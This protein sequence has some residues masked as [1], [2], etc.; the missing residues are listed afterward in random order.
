M[1]TDSIKTKAP[2]VFTQFE[3]LVTGVFPAEIQRL[4]D[5]VPEEDLSVAILL[6]KAE[7]AKELQTLAASLGMSTQDF[8]G[9]VDHLSSLKQE[10]HLDLLEENLMQALLE[11]LFPEDR[12]QIKRHLDGLP[13]QIT[14]AEFNAEINEEFGTN[15]STRGPSDIGNVITK[16]K[17]VLKRNLADTKPPS[18]GIASDPAHNPHREL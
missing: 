4:E 18:A 17:N 8:E 14:V 5:T 1:P 13:P 15:L 2:D 10:K 16:M 3:K 6:E 9:Y 11:D 12:A 7:Q